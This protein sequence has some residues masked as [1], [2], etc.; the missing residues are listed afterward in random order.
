M[1]ITEFILSAFEAYITRASDRSLKEKRR[2]QASYE[3]RLSNFQKEVLEELSRFKEYIDSAR[4]VIPEIIDDAE[5][6]AVKGVWIGRAKNILEEIILRKPSRTPFIH[7]E[8]QDLFSAAEEQIEKLEIDIDR[9]VQEIGRKKIGQ[10]L[11]K[12]IDRQAQ[13]IGRKKIEKI[14]VSK[15]ETRI[16]LHKS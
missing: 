9:R 16:K 3:A 7:R 14:V 6:M 15:P 11:E 13:E 2:K 1:V 4:K 10:K 5:L 8:M 12:D